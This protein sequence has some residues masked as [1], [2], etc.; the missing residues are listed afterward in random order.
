MS[1]S[2]SPPGAGV[3]WGELPETV[4]ARLAEIRAR[5]GRPGLVVAAYDTE[6]FGH[7]WH[8]GP[9]F[10]ERVLRLLPRAG[11]RLTTLRGRFGAPLPADRRE[12][13]AG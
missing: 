8:E 2:Q 4:R 10:L 5:D 13:R 9:A 6:L 12:G 7:W 11:V 3:D 1:E